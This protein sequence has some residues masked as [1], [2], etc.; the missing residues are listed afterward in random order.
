MDFS[1]PGSSVY[2]IFQ[3]RILEWVAISFSRRFSQPRDRTLFSCTAGR[4]FTDWAMREAPC[5]L[6]KL[7]Q[8]YPTLCDPIDRSPPSSSVPGILQARTLEWVAISFSKA[9][10]WKVESEVAQSCSTLSDPMD[11]SL[12]GSSIHGISQARVR[13]WGAIAFSNMSSYL[14]P[15]HRLYNTKSEP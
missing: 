9:W 13:E 10:K 8:S 4:F 5:L 1:P 11:C 6:A 15:N 3:A 2:G 12:R 7:H 14:Y